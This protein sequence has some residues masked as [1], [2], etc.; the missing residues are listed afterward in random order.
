MRRFVDPSRHLDLED[1]NLLTSFLPPVIF[2]TAAW[3]A[4]G[5]VALLANS[6][7]CLLRSTFTVFD[8]IERSVMLLGSIDVMKNCFYKVTKCY[9]S[10]ILLRHVEALMA[11]QASGRIPVLAR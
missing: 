6:Q 9:Q 5:A 8:Y 1:S 11:P 7:S 4:T 3:E 10:A 2:N